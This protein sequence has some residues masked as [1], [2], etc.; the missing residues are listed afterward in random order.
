MHTER[1]HLL[2]LELA[3]LAVLQRTQAFVVEREPLRLM[4]GDSAAH[5]P[6]SATVNVR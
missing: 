4:A 1:A 3:V 5:L 6:L 2:Y